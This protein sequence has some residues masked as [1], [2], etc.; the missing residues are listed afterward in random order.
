MSGGPVFDADGRVVGVHGQ[1]RLDKREIYQPEKSKLTELSAFAVVETGFNLAI[2]INTF[3]VAARMEPTFSG[4]TVSNAPSTGKQANLVAPQTAED[5]Y[6]RGLTRAEQGDNQGAVKAF[7]QALA[8]NPK[9]ADAYFNRGVER[10]S[11]GDKQGAIEDYTQAIRLDPKFAMA[12]SNRGTVRADLGDKQGAIEDFAQAIRLDPKFASAYYNRGKMR[13]DLGDK[14]GA[15]EDY[16]QAI[17]LGPKF[18]LAYANRGI[19]RSEL[20]DKRG[21][22]EDFREEAGLYLEQKDMDTYNALLGA[23]KKLQSN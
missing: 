10:F 4:L 13:A 16:S 23:I 20:N 3:I 7:D 5:F 6:V 12:Y 2:P 17:R 14:Q 9:N 8:L 11:L 18:A 19:V 15:I 1:A 22:I 21:A